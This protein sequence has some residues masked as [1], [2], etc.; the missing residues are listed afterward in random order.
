[1]TRKTQKSRKLERL[2]L[3]KIGSFRKAPGGDGLNKAGF[4]LKRPAYEIST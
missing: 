3:T 2:S 1:L 4:A